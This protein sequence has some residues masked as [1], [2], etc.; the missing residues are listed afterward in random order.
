MCMYNISHVLYITHS[1][2]KW[3]IYKGSWINQNCLAGRVF[4]PTTTTIAITFF[5][6]YLCRCDI[7]VAG[8]DGLTF[9]GSL[10]WDQT[11]SPGSWI[12]NAVLITEHSTQPTEKTSYEKRNGMQNPNVLTPLIIP[13]VMLWG[14]NWR[15]WDH[16]WKI[17]CVWLFSLLG[18]LHVGSGLG[19]RLGHQEHWD[20]LSKCELMTMNACKTCNNFSCRTYNPS[21]NPDL[22]LHLSGP[23]ISNGQPSC[24]WWR[25][26]RLKHNK[27]SLLRWQ[28]SSSCGQ[29]LL[30]RC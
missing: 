6:V 21:F 23:R 27:S 18:L 16:L 20:W 2:F 12:E 26:P 9:S 7:C 3:Y 17:T 15:K 8:D 10:S 1:E 22:P 25:V 11:L 29:Y 28:L 14:T 5:R 19:S 13:F 30:S 4:R 24:L